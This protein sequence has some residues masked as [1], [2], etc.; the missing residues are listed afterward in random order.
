MHITYLI[1]NGFDLGL[2]LK[3]KFSDFYQH[4]TKDR[5]TDPNIFALQ[6][7]IAKNIENWSDFELQLGRYTES[8]SA[9]DSDKFLSC[10]EDFDEKFMQ[11]L[12]HEQKKIA[13]CDQD[14]AHFMQS[15]YWQ[16]HN[17][18]LLR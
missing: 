8:F 9:N 12:A 10:K 14:V 16:D 2:G 7:D 4:Y 15:I 3:T 18:T 13:I 17:E 6:E 1:G 5:S 11:Y